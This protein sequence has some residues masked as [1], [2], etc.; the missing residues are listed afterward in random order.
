MEAV[1]E[2]RKKLFKLGKYF[3]LLNRNEAN[4]VWERELCKIIK[5]E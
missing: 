4:S 2:E 1:V 5:K 3:K